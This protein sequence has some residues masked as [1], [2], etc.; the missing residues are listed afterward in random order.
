MMKCSNWIEKVSP[1][2]I[3]LLL[4][5]YFSPVYDGLKQP[6]YYTEEH[7]LRSAFLEIILEEFNVSFSLVICAVELHSKITRFIVTLILRLW[8]FV[9][10]LLQHPVHIS[11]TQVK[12]SRSKTSQDFGPT[13][14]VNLG[15]VPCEVS[16]GLG[17]YI[18]SSSLRIRLGKE[19]R[20]DL[21]WSKP[22]RVSTISLFSSDFI[23]TSISQERRGASRLITLARW[24]TSNIMVPSFLTLKI[25]TLCWHGL[26]IF[27]PDSSCHRAE[28]LS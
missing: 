16:R 28:L 26:E 19:R 10:I 7:P 25:P 27:P 23:Q 15:L 9:W 20:I 21:F 2:G 3:N 12:S 13:N 8:P 11:I 17:I 18:L 4:F 14:L 5:D 22:W 1:F 6:V 24:L